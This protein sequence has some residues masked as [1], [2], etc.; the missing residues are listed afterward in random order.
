MSKKKEK[1]PHFWPI[2]A[3]LRLNIG[4]LLTKRSDSVS[5][6]IIYLTQAF[7]GSMKNEHG[8]KLAIFT[9]MAQNGEKS[10]RWVT[11][12]DHRGFGRF[13][14]VWAPYQFQRTQLEVENVKK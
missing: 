6:S 3:L 10:W 11:F 13:F 9:K 5:C 7:L 14:W 8:L 12:S 1:R 2:L 4:E